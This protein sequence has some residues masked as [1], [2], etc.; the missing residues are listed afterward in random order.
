[1]E[2]AD[3][4]LEAKPK[5]ES[6]DVFHKLTI[7]RMRVRTQQCLLPGSFGDMSIKYDKVEKK[8]G[9]LSAVCVSL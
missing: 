2:G 8:N 5:T 9:E 4:G 3:S 1:V 7:F 6:M